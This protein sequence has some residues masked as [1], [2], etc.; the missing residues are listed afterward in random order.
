MPKIDIEEDEIEEEESDEQFDEDE[1]M[2][3]PKKKNNRPAG[4][5]KDLPKAPVI[6][7][8]FGVVASQPVRIVDVESNEIVAEGDYLIAQALT[9]VLERLERIEN[10]LG[11]MTGN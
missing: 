4:P 8:R 11:S 2:E 3:E 1:E 5:R 10:T 6:K 9:D 7:R